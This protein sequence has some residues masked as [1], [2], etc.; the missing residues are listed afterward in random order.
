MS[1][2]GKIQSKSKVKKD[3]SKLFT[4]LQTIRVELNYP[5]FYPVV[6]EYKSRRGFTRQKFL[7]VVRACYSYAYRHPALYG[8]WRHG[9]GDLYLEDVR[10]V[11]KSNLFRLTVG[12]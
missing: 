9:I 8:I 3:G 7:N 10:R 2:E 5:M 4:R 6:L 11:G 12:S 1:I